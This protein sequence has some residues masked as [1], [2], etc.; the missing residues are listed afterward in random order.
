MFS[1]TQKLS[2]TTTM[3]FFAKIVNGFYKT[4]ACAKRP[5]LSGAKSGF[6]K[7]V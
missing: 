2:R 1:L 6:L 3:D 5:L 4:T 7:Q